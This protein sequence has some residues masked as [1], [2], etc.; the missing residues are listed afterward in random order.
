LLATAVAVPA[1]AAVGTAALAAA[2]LPCDIYAAGGTPCVT[3]H[4]TTRA[5]LGSYSGPLYQVQRVSDRGLL[6]VG[7][8]APG[9]AANTAPQVS[10]C[11]GTRCTI[12]KIHD[13]TANHSDLPIS[14]GGAFAGP[15]P[16]GTDI[17]ADAMALPVTVAG[18]RVYGAL[19]T[20]GTGYRID[21]ARN[22]PTGAQ[23]ECIYMVTSSNAV[24]AAC[25][26]DYGS[27]ETDNH[28]D[29]NPP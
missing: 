12:V 19:F 1:S 10:F 23:P 21:A 15:G 14:T 24:N 9:G 7:L 5:L 6:D 11:A 26:F 4:S 2:P 22:V 29:G 8:R 3:A 17:G 25:C 20:P 27:G 13:Q 18:Q 28:D 16:G